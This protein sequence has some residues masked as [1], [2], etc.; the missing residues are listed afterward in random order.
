[1]IEKN[2]I[3]KEKEP[4]RQAFHFYMNSLEGTSQNRGYIP[5]ASYSH[6]IGVYPHFAGFETRPFRTTWHA[7]ISIQKPGKLHNRKWNIQLM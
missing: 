7:T 2:L 4:T 3:P 1:M 5:I 6:L